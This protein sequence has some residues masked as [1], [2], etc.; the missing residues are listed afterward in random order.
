M[1]KKKKISKIMNTFRLVYNFAACDARI[2]ETSMI[3]S[4]YLKV[5]GR[6]VWAEDTCQK[7]L[8]VTRDVE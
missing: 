5:R 1:G 2:L 6:N 8:D 4:S 7:R 3:V